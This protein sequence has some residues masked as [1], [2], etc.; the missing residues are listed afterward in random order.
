MRM[1]PAAIAGLSLV[2]AVA[3]LAPA[4]ANAVATASGN[5]SSGLVPVFDPDQGTSKMVTPAAANAII[6]RYWTPE[7]LASAVPAPQPALTGSVRTPTEPTGPAR[8]VSAPTPAKSG[9]IK[10]NVAFTNA[11]GRAFF[12]DPTDGKNYSCSGGTIN[13]GKRRLVLTAGHC[14]HGGSGKQWM[15]NWIFQP[16]YQ[17]G[18]G[19]PGTFPAYQLWAQSGWFNNNDRH[20]DYAFAIMQNNQF[21]QRVVDRVGGNGLTINPGRPFVTAI[22]Y[23]SNFANGEQQAFCQV[24]LERKSLFNSDQ[25]LNCFMGAGASGQPWLRDYS[26]ATGLGYAVSDNSYTERAD[27]GPPEFGPYYDSDTSALYFAAENASP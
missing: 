24:T 18:A 19:A 8:D 5:V 14:V 3:F 9:G 1:L 6:T 20:Y 4:P 11:V 22:G 2:A 16:G 21:G 15:Q 17:F 7:R 27:H 26:D 23:P 25:Q 10:P 13:S 12:R